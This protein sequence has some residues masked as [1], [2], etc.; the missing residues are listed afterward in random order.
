MLLSSGET[1]GAPLENRIFQAHA[2]LNKNDVDAGEKLAAEIEKA[3]P[4]DASAFALSGRVAMFNSDT[5]RAESLSKKAL[6]IDPNNSHALNTLAAIALNSRHYDAAK[7]LLDRATAI[8]DRN[9][10][11][12]YNRGLL[13]QKQG[14]TLEAIA[15]Y[16]ES[17]RLD[18]KYLGAHI[19]LAN[20]YEEV[21]RFEDGVAAARKAADIAPEDPRPYLNMGVCLRKLK[22]LPEAE[23][24][25]Q[26]GIQLAPADPQYP[27]NLAFVYEDMNRAEDAEKY[28]LRTIEIAPN[29]VRSYVNLGVLYKHMKRFDEAVTILKKGIEISPNLYNLYAELT[30]VYRLKGDQVSA[31]AALERAEFIDP[32]R[33]KKLRR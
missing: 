31:A 5:S 4:G 23:K 8:G 3:S 18:P 30:K 7:V 16:E 20:V 32:E 28:Y 25:Y 13:A 9:P 17:V 11:T 2:V 21:S 15:F 14:D 29:F 6:E 22:K 24:A 33:A 1:I 10:R 19:N 12:S 26:K 27:Y